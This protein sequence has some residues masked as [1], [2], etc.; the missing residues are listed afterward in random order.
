VLDPVEPLPNCKEE[1]LANASKNSPLLPLSPAGTAV[2]S[3][4]TAPFFLFNKDGTDSFACADEF[5][6]ESRLP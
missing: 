5:A 1:S 3:A 4:E 2:Q 6:E